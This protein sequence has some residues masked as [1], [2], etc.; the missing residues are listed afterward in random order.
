MN[1]AVTEG[2]YFEK[3]EEFLE[4]NLKN[5]CLYIYYGENPWSSKNVAS[6]WPELKNLLQKYKV[7]TTYLFEY[8]NELRVFKTQE[9]V[10]RIQESISIAIKI[11]RNSWLLLK[12]S[13][14]EKLL[15]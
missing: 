3:F 14:N 12:D 13:I 10:D 1:Y 8:V 7:N 2:E 5:K 11:M 4:K 15:Y 6:A 9:E